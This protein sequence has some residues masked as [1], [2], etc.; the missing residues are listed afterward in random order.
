M[1][2]EI[3]AFV[4]TNVLVYA[5]S[6]DDSRKQERASS[7]VERG[8]VEG[9]YAV[10]TQVL[11]ELYVNVTRK[12]RIK[13]PASQALEYV[14][15]LTEWHVVD[16]VPDLVLSALGLAERMRISPW[17]AAILEAARK[18]GCGLV[19]SEDLGAGQSYAGIRVENPF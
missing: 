7:I 14:R 3:A 18:A 13:L 2:G 1:R 16:M 5:V 11:M 8:F 15:S 12:T 17:D 6:T 4:D 9:C 19:L 10:S